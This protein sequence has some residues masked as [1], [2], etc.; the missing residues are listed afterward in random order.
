[1]SKHHAIDLA[2]KIIVI[3]TVEAGTRSKTEIVKYLACLKVRFVPFSK[4]KISYVMCIYATTSFD[5][6]KK[7]LRQAAHPDIEET[8]FIWFDT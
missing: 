1:M 2:T 5:Q 8:L 3:D 4:R 7:R 6:G